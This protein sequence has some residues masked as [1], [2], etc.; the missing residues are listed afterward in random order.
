M[1][2][3]AKNII[4]QDNGYV[5]QDIIEK[6]QCRQR[7]HWNVYYKRNQTNGFADRHYVKHEFQELAKALG[8]LEIA[9]KEKNGKFKDDSEEERQICKENRSQK[10]LQ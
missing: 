10:D 4:S 3:V 7:L 1:T 9:Q 8:G 2:Q 6:I 5:R